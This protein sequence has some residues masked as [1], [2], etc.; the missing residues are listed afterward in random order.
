MRYHPLIPRFPG[1]K[2]RHLKEHPELFPSSPVDVW[3]A[4]FAGSGAD[5]LMML[6]NGFAK[7]AIVAESDPALRCI[8]ESWL[9][10]NHEH[11]Y[12][13][14]ERWQTAIQESGIEQVWN[15][16]KASLSA[17]SLEFRAATSLAM[18]RIAFGGVMRHGQEN[19]KLN[20]KFVRTQIPA[21]LKWRYQ[22]PPPADV[23][24]FDDCIAAIQSAKSEQ[25]MIAG[26]IDPP[27]YIPRYFGRMVACYP[28]HKPHSAET[29]RLGV[30]ALKEALTLD[31]PH[32]IYSN[33]SSREH[34]ALVSDLMVGATE[35]N[36]GRFSDL[37]QGHGDPSVF[38]NERLW[39]KSQSYQQQLSLFSA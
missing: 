27:Y 15:E 11:V 26:W 25:G 29:L 21:F 2:R 31:I 5:T 17:D 10:G 28:W 33:Y 7:R 37:H 32:L 14:I 38:V 24:L 12:R 23:S 16:M 6:Q 9:H 19:G 39:L 30:G 1:S 4:P 13:G 35:I 3:L 8:W 18:R 36:C 20:I 34:D 22:F